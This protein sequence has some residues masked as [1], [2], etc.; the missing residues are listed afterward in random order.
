MGRT[1][2]ARAIGVVAAAALLLAAC[3]NSDLPA[4]RRWES[5]HF[6]YL[7]RASDLQ[8]CP[9]ILGP[10][11]E[12]F[13]LLQGY[14]GFDWA[15]RAKVTYE[16]MVDA[17]DL[18]QHSDCRDFPACTVNSMVE[19]PH[20]MDLHEL[21]HAYLAPTGSPPPVLVEGPAVVLACAAQLF[22]KPKPTQSWDQLAALD[23]DPDTR[24]AV[25]SAGAW[26]V[27]YLLAHY[28]PR[29][30]TTIYQRLPSH[31]D[32][33]TMDAAFKD[34]YG[35]SL[36]SIWAAALAGTDP[37]DACIWQCSQPALPLDGT[38]VA[39]DGVCGTIDLFHSLPLA[40]T[41]LVSLTSTAATLQLKR[42]GP[43]PLPMAWANPGVLNLYDLLP[44]S[45]F[46]ESSP[47]A[48]TM[49]VQ[50]SLPSL[51]APTCTEA[52]D[53]AP[54]AGFKSVHLTGP[55]T[56]EPQWFLPLP[57]P[58]AGSSQLSAF[59]GGANTKICASCDPAS[60]VS[61]IQL[62]GWTWAP[63]QKVSVAPSPFPP[64]SYF[65]ISIDWF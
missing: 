62:A 1:I 10:L 17:T 21:V 32:A 52:T 7:T 65:Q 38:P 51:L 33:S 19:S 53:L 34:V 63:G 16:K 4:D 64:D 6:R 56:S 41:T 8:I 31:A 23:Y 59:S 45:Y 60:C 28:D 27:G 18:E 5:A 14:L 44:G 2:P 25:Y 3:G 48:G 42:C 39:T 22:G 50:G 40:S 12:H 57:P 43:T 24:A 61:L 54:F 30:F 37:L 11:E 9:D 49:M 15:P 26:L 29:L 46:V 35:E 55:N 47:D 20:A 58:P 36:A 13:A